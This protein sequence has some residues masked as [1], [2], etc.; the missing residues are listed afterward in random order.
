[1]GYTSH[2]KE[3]LATSCNSRCHT[4]IHTIVVGTNEGMMTI[5]AATK[6]DTG[7][8]DATIMVLIH[9]IT[10]A[11]LRADMGATTMNVGLMGV[12][13]VDHMAATNAN[14][15]DEMIEIAEEMIMGADRADEKITGGEK[16]PTTTTL[17]IAMTT[18]SNREAVDTKA[19]AVEAMA[20]SPR[21]QATDLCSVV[22]LTVL[23]HWALLKS[24]ALKRGTTTSLLRFSIT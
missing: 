13:K 18:A 17:L 23:L 21:A 10:M 16:V 12:T 5:A 15:T 2:S 19:E 6:E 14:L 11:A 20:S 8:I 9:V 7:A 22:I 3:T 24:T 1:M 4:T